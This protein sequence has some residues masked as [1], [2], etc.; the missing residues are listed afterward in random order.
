MW[1]GEGLVFPIAV[2]AEQ[3]VGW[4]S[5][6]KARAAFPLRR[7]PPA[8][9]QPVLCPVP[10]LY[11]RLYMIDLTYPVAYRV[12]Q[13]CSRQ[14][15]CPS[16]GQCLLLLLTGLVVLIMT[17]TSLLMG[18]RALSQCVRTCSSQSINQVIEANRTRLFQS[19]IKLELVLFFFWYDF[20]HL[21][22]SLENLLC[23]IAYV[24]GL[25]LCFGTLYVYCLKFSL[26]T[27]VY[28]QC[29]WKSLFYI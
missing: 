29:P 16:L 12:L 20:C 4:K 26:E 3:T 21:T 7:W 1:H 9:A 25:S 13:G 6:P 27:S 11:Q 14:R 19:F 8:N 15:S 10:R 24:S 5:N 23:C 17:W 28:N 22:T 2:P 18:C